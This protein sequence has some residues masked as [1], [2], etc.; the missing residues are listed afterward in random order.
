MPGAKFEMFKD[1]KGEYRFHLRGS[2]G[3]IVLA[4]QGYNQREG[5]LNG[6]ESVRENAPDAELEELTD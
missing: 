3:R 4:S 1:N 5:C 6:I 2:N